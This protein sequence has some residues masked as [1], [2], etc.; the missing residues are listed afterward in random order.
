MQS[1]KINKPVTEITVRGETVVQQNAMKCRFWIV[2]FF[3]QAIVFKEFYKLERRLL[4]S[5]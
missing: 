5:R 1:Q 3:Y 2:L 4:N